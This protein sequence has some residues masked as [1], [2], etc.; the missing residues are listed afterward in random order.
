MKGHILLHENNRQQWP[1]FLISW[2][3]FGLLLS[4][5]WYVHP[6]FSLVCF[7]PYFKVLFQAK[8][9]LLYYVQLFVL[10]LTWNT[11]VTYWIYQLRPL[12]GL[13]TLLTN[14]MLFLM[15]VLIWHLCSRSFLK[16][17]QGMM[18]LVCWLLF[19]YLHHI[20]D[21][22]W[23]WLTVGNVFGS[24]PQWVLWYAYAGVLG[25]SAWILSSNYLIYQVARVSRPGLKKWILPG[26]TILLPV[27]I[28]LG[29]KV[30]SNAQPA[31]MVSHITAAALSVHD[32]DS[33]SDIRKLRIVDSL[34]VSDKQPKEI[35]L[36]PEALLT[37][38]VWL[39]RFP[40]SRQYDL[41]KQSLK[42][43]QASHIITGAQ[44]NVYDTTGIVNAG[45]E[46]ADGISAYNAALMIDTSDM[47]SIK[48]KKVLVPVEEYV[49][50]YLSFLPL[51][52]R[53]RIERNNSDVFEISG[54][55]YLIGICYEVVNSIFIA[56]RVQEQ[57]SALLM[58]SS[59]SFFGQS[60]VGRE[61]YM[62]ICRLRCVE[63][64]LPLVKSS[65]D[66]IVM[67][68]SAGGEILEAKRTSGPYLLHAAVRSPGI[69]FYHM[70]V[71]F[72]PWALLLLLGGVLMVNFFLKVKSR[73]SVH[74]PSRLSIYIN[75]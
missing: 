32:K 1:Q 5:S 28:S 59:E 69:S 6:L 19:E 34:L 16:K 73:E 74:A 42:R 21:F 26:F 12:K 60:E 54:R 25:G 23:T 47:I 37:D 58:L 14:S 18:L 71:P 36:L 46:Q 67:S 24:H 11:A 55:Q 49:P 44:L 57:T 9:N 43:W 50:S 61:Q 48:L 29:L 68:L 4:M 63:N 8:K 40:F 72:V 70:I 41:I 27:V 39:D 7:V 30:R 52:K 64:N 15:P 10:N 33:I 2:L 17:G 31:G 35:V 45:P 62:N 22:S 3:F 38:Q 65:N 53:F 13:A 56:N 75:D 51:K 66:G 20:W